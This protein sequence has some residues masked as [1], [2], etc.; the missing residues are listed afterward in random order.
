MTTYNPLYIG[1]GVVTAIAGYS[2]RPTRT[3]TVAIV[4]LIVIGL[5]VRNW[6]TAKAQWDQIVTGKGG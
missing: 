2:F 5:L 1:L 3:A 4:S 6:P